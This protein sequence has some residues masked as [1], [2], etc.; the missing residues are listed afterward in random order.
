MARL[1]QIVIDCRDPAALAR[2]WA[3]L[4]DGK[5][6]DRERGWSQVDAPGFPCLSFQPVA[7]AKPGKNRLHLDIAVPPGR[8]A[9]APRPPSGWVPARSV[10]RCGTRRAR[11]R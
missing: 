8:V 6:I 7:E 3:R 5:A 10:W 2:F 1:D 11:S 9:D 4:L